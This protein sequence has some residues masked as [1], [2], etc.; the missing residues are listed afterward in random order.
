MPQVLVE[1]TSAGEAARDPQPVAARP[2]F[3]LRRGFRR[4]IAGWLFISPWLVGFVGLTALPYLASAV[5]AFMSWDM[6][7]EISFIGFRN[8]QRLAQ[9]PL[10]R[11]SLTN[12][13]YYTVLHVPG[14]VIISLAVAGLLNLNVRGMSFYRVCYYLPSVTSGVGMSIIWIWLFSPG[15]PLNAFLGLLGIQGP[16]WLTSTTWAMP[17]LILMS[18]WGVGNT[19]VMFLAGLQ[20]VPAHLYDA[21]EVDGAN[22][23]QRIRSV[24]LPMMTPYIFLSLV[25]NIIGSFNVFTQAL[26][27][28]EG[29]PDNATLFIFLYIY[30]NAWRYYKMGYA[31]AMAWVLAAIILVFTLIQF[32]IANRWVYYEFQD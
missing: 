17:A 7:R 10:F 21:A 30:L 6:T 27:M 26:L 25:M 3:W 18:F 16:N 29:G 8:F 11:V 28:T 22:A 24:T 20:G 9:D 32:A 15:G 12:T 2:P 19:M 23:W 4:E 13:L 1:R 31:S 5:L 14:I